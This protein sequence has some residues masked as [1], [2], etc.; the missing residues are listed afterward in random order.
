[1]SQTI[2]DGGSP[3]KPKAV[4][5]VLCYREMGRFAAAIAWI[6]GKTIDSVR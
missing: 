6:Y 4:R 1:M 5:A 2:A 3:G